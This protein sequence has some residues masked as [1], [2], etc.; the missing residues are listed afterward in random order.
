MHIQEIYIRNRVYSYC[1]DNLAETKNYKKPINV[2][3]KMFHKKSI[4]SLHHHKLM[5]KIEKH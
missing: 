5:G 3:M 4:K 2:S 1:F